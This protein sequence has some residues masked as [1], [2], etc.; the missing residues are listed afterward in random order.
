MPR[1]VVFAQETAGSKSPDGLLCTCHYYYRK[2]G[3]LHSVT[4]GTREIWHYRRT[5]GKAPP[6]FGASFGAMAKADAEP[7]AAKTGRQ[8]RSPSLR[9][10][11]R[12]G[13]AKETT[14]GKAPRQQRAEEKQVDSIA[15][16]RVDASKYMDRLKQWN[17]SAYGEIV[18][19]L[20][21]FKNEDL[22]TRWV[23]NEVSGRTS[24]RAQPS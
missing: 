20:K 18:A 21:R 8:D 22:T 13:T 5:G 6:L 12:T 14:G 15:Q 23:M 10:S 9:R 19:V 17:L 3:S 11:K 7:P 2:D 24:R 1:Q 4:K 16:R